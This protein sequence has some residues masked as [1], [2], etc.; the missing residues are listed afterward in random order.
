M[1]PSLGKRNDLSLVPDANV[2][3]QAMCREWSGARMGV[4]WPVAAMTIPFRCGIESVANICRR[5][6][7]TDLTSDSITAGFEA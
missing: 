4:C 7:V 6:G 5:C 1:S 3:I 2:G